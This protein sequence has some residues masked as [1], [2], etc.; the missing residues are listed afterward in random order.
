MSI[1]LYRTP[2][3]IRGLCAAAALAVTFSIGL[4]LDAIADYKSAGTM[5]S[6]ASAPVLL[7]K[8]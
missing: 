4:G 2:P 8:R 1:K 5:A 6:A 3:L 7:A